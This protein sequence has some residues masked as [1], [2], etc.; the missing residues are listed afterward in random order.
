[1]SI[2]FSADSTRLMLPLLGTKGIAASNTVLPTPNTAS[3]ST[4]PLLQDVAIDA[5]RPQLTPSVMANFLKKCSQ[6]FT[7]KG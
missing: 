5:A 7:P 3:Q 6:A 1:M 4:N 2:K